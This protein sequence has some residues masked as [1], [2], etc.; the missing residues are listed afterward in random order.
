MIMSGCL[1]TLFGNSLKTPL[2]VRSL[3]KK[4]A[5]K[6]FNDCPIGFFSGKSLFAR[7]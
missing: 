3:S 6:S 4:S 5:E 7:A 2:T 1:I